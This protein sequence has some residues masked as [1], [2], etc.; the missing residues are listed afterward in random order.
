MTHVCSMLKFQVAAIFDLLGLNDK[1]I[2]AILCHVSLDDLCSVAFTCRR[3]YSIARRTFVLDKSNLSYHPQCKFPNMTD[4]EEYLNADEKWL[5]CEGHRGGKL[6]LVQA[7]T[8]FG[9]LFEKIELDGYDLGEIQEKLMDKVNKHCCDTLESF[10]LTD[11]IWTPEFQAHARPI[12]SRLKNLSIH[13][14][15]DLT[16]ILQAVQNCVVLELQIDGSETN[17]FDSTFPKLKKLQF[18][19]AWNENGIGFNEFLLRHR[20][21]KDLKLLVPDNTD[22]TAIGQLH[23]LESLEIEGRRWRIAWNAIDSEAFNFNKLKRLIC[24]THDETDESLLLQRLSKSAATET[25]QYLELQNGQLS[26]L[27]SFINLHELSL[28]PGWGIDVRLPLMRSL[29]ILRLCSV[30]AD[31][32]FFRDLG[33]LTQLEELDLMCVIL[34]DALTDADKLP[35]RNLNQLKKL[36]VYRLEGNHDWLKHLGSTDTLRSLHIRQS[37]IIEGVGRYHNLHELTF[38]T[39]SIVGDIQEACE[40]LCHLKSLKT[41]KILEHRGGQSAYDIYSRVGSNATLQEL[42]LIG[43]ESLTSTQL[44]AL[45]AFT[46]MRTLDIEQEIFNWQS[47]TELIAHLPSLTKLILRYYDGIDFNEHVFRGILELCKQQR[48]K[49]V[50]DLHV[51]QVIDDEPRFFYENDNCRFVEVRHY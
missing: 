43:I 20:Q 30:T 39:M 5:S 37:D 33:R 41:L 22:L 3:L 50:V 9:N 16:R 51:R 10:K 36:M 48:R 44:L 15:R 13:G 18:G 26:L 19:M 21:L 46:Q 14:S 24:S 45:D 49:I 2:I 28:Y 23:E 17:I 38:S 6:E 31:R 27:S 1:C 4:M 25:L 29:K 8:A 47:L 7:L 12:L 40:E 32:D 11:F 42:S 35:L 34:G